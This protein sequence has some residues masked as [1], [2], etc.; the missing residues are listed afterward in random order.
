MDKKDECT[1]TRLDSEVY[2]LLSC[3][4]GQFASSFSCVKHD[5]HKLFGTIDV[6]QFYCV[7]WSHKSALRLTL[8]LLPTT[9]FNLSCVE[10]LKHAVCHF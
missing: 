5:F 1:L 2:G 4:E 9:P 6:F 7:H 10:S 3:E 8:L